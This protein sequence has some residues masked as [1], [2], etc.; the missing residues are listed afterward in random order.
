MV[1]F[2]SRPLYHG[3]MNPPPHHSTYW[4]GGRMGFRASLNAVEERKILYAYR[5]SNLDSVVVQAVA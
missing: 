4:L 2:R 1:G 5:E 3:A